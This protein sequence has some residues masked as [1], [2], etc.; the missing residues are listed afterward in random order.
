MLCHLQ[1]FLLNGKRIYSMYTKSLLMVAYL[2][3]SVAISGGLCF[4]RPKGPS[5]EEQ[6]RIE[7]IRAE[8]RERRYQ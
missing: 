3:S 8:A 7:Q 4:N 5:K 1:L 2:L 6:A